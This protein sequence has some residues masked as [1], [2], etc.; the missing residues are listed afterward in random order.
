M[1]RQLIAEIQKRLVSGENKE[2][3]PGAVLPEVLDGL[4]VLLI[5]QFPK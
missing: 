4:Q 2:T 3:I 5:E 1:C